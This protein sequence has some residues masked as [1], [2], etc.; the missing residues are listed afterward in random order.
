M[1]LLLVIC[2]LLVSLNQYNA[3]LNPLVRRSTR[4]Y[5]TILYGKVEVG[6]TSEIPSG[7][8]KIV[9]T[10]AGSVIV[11]N[12]G[13]SFFAV[14]AKCPH[15]GLPMKKGAIGT[16]ETGQPTITCNFHNSKFSLKDGSCQQWCSGVLGIPNTG[17]FANAMGKLGGAE[18]SP[19]TVYPVTVDENGV[20]TLEI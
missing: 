12:V 1:H 2:I 9:D 4:Y 8:R 3:F 18:K 13:G 15:L 20:L 10:N 19:A 6:K 16:D 17:F 14:N 11:T 7:E 5:S